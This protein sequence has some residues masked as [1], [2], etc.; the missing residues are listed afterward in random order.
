MHSSPECS[1]GYTKNIN[2]DWA[3]ISFFCYASRTLR[4]TLHGVQLINLS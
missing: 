4:T 1:P 2:K 3:I